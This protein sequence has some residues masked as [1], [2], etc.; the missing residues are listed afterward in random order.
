MCKI[1]PFPAPAPEKSVRKGLVDL[2]SSAKEAEDKAVN[3]LKN[4]LDAKK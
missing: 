2:L 4:T 1:W 3:I